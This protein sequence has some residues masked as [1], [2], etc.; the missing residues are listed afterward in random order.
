MKLM[1]FSNTHFP[2]LIA[3]FY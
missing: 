3:P 1:I 2:Q